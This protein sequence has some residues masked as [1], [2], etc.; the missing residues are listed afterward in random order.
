[1]SRTFR[2]L[3]AGAVAV[4]ALLVALT[5]CGGV[6]AHLRPR[7]RRESAARHQQAGTATGATPLA[8]VALPAGTHLP[9]ALRFKGELAASVTVGYAARCGVYPGYG[10]LAALELPLAGRVAS[11]TIQLPMFNGP[12]LYRVG[13]PAGLAT[14]VATTRLSTLGEAQAGSVVVSP[15]GRGGSLELYFG[16]ARQGSRGNQYAEVVSGNWTCAPPGL[17]P[18]VSSSFVTNAYQALTVSGAMSGHVGAA[19]VP[20][21]SLVDGAPNCGVY[22]TASGVHF[23]VAMVVGLAGHPFI[24]DVQLQQYQGAGQYYPAFTTASL[25][26]ETNW[27]TGEVVPDGSVG[28]SG[29]IRSSNWAA[30]GGDFRLDAGL[31]SGLMAIRFMDRTGASFV[32]TGAWSC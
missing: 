1:M 31:D 25:P 23:N 10:Y 9:E 16:S 29:A 22:H 21:S 19:D 18:T 11:L 3:A 5:G 20:G 8:A 13:S 12:G 26:M 15:G 32:V 7:R 2:A 4:A 14:A 6:P 28:S 24:L 17:N 27:A 30:V